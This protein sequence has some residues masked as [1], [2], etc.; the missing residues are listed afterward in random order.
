MGVDSRKIERLK[1]H[2]NQSSGD[3]DPINDSVSQPKGWNL[4]PDGGLALA[5][6]NDDITDVSGLTPMSAMSRSDNASVFVH[7][8]E[9]TA[10]KESH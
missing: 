2:I 8:F 5:N 7:N 6:Y 1:L 4:V 9:G 3:S 10:L